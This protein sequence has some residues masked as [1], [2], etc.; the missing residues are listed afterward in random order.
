MTPAQKLRT[1]LEGL[2]PTFIKLGQTLSIHRDLL[3]DEYTEALQGLQ[4][5][6]PFFDSVTA[7]REVTRALGATI[8]DLFREF[9]DVPMAAASIAQVHKARLKDGRRV[10]VK[11]RRPEIKPM[12]ASDMRLL[13]LAARTLSAALPFLQRYKPLDLINELETN[14]RKEL[15]FRNEARNIRRFEEAFKD[16]D[17]VHIPR[18]IDDMYTES[19]L[20][21]E[22]S[23]GLSVDDPEARKNGTKLAKA[24]V[25]AYLYQFF[26]LGVFHGD[27]HPGNLFIMKDGKICFHDFGLVGFLDRS[28]RRNLAA[29]IL[30]LVNLDSEWLLDAYL[31]LG[32]IAG[33]IDRTKF[34]H[35]IEEL[36]KDYA[37][38]PLKEWSFAEAFLR[39]ARVGRGKYIRIPHDQ[40]VFMRAIFLMENVVRS[41][42]KDYN[43]LDGLIEKS[44]ENVKAAAMEEESTIT[45]TR[46]KYEA[47]ALAQS[48]PASIAK[49]ARTI[50]T[51]GLE[52]RIRI[53]DLGKFGKRVERSSNRLVL[54]LLSVGLFVAASLLMQHSLGPRLWDVP[55]LSTLGYIAA[56]WLTVKLLHAVFRSGEL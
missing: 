40:L 32:V 49:W 9:D 20:V 24:F 21:Q 53:D 28:T 5:Q 2:G 38:L 30:A 7:R 3:P 35:G 55:I 51:E 47:K 54:A 1:T 6:A 50:R 19:V 25:D 8:D 34:R 18:V 12:V 10:V 13:K 15:D 39:I 23:G 26:V 16:S 56:L 27:P 29:F 46:L 43:L 31:D 11:I 52:P 41:L 36:L 14:L 33:E 22:L 48:M 37:A 4:D 42:D 44:E 45:S 17:T